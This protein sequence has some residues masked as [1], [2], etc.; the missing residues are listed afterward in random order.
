MYDLKRSPWVFSCVGMHVHL[1]V[2]YPGMHQ[3]LETGDCPWM[4]SL[5]LLHLILWGRFSNLSPEIVYW[6]SL[7]CQDTCG[8]PCLPTWHLY[9][10]LRI[11]I[12]LLVFVQQAL[13]PMSSF[14]GVRMFLLSLLLFCQILVWW[15]LGM[16]FVGGNNVLQCP[17]V[18]HSCQ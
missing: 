6:F 18:G 11:Q 15:F 5:I 4:S 8:P 3:N 17:K 7:S 13:C 10:V 12:L 16:N 14:P 2:F 1:W 9:W